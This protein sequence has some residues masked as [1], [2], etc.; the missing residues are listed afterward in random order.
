MK[1][2]LCEAG[3]QYSYAI[4]IALLV[5]PETKRPLQAIVGAGSWGCCVTN[6][7]SELFGKVEFTSISSTNPPTLG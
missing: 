7:M 3:Q 5:D 6:T 2:T 1:C 4:A